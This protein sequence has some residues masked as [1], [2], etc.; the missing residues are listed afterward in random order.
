[1]FL[2]PRRSQDTIPKK[3]AKWCIVNVE[4]CIVTNATAKHFLDV[5]KDRA[6]I[7]EFRWNFMYNLIY[8]AKLF[9]GVNPVFVIFCL[10]AIFVTL[11]LILS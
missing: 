5:V 3:P 7:H 9:Y 10:V 4:L 11:Y 2:P 1:M 6:L 8:E